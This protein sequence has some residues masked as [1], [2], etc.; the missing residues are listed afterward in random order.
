TTISWDGDRLICSQRGEKRDRGWT[1][2]LE[3]N[4]L[5]LELRVE[6]VVAKQEFRRK[7]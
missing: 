1:H 5:H 7:K 4:T 2:W 3:G 6:G